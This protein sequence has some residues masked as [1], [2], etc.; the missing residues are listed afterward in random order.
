[1]IRV[2]RLEKEGPAGRIDAGIQQGQAG[3]ILRL[4]QAEGGNARRGDILIL[5]GIDGLDA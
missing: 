2:I 3:R 4:I 1:M 5:P